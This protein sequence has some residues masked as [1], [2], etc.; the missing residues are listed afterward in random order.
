MTVVSDTMAYCDPI[1]GETT[2]NVINEG[3]N[4]GKNLYHI[5]INLSQVIS[6]DIDL[7]E[8][9]YNH[10][11]KLC[12]EVDG[13]LIIPLKSKGTKIYFT[14]RTLTVQKFEI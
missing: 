11:I 6:Y 9:L 14:T 12:I 7:R 10:S 2:I 13:Q 3:I 5:L 4:Y 1:T 8:N